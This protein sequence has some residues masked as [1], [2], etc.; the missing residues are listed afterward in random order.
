MTFM[1]LCYIQN[2][3]TWCLA[4]TTRHP[5]FLWYNPMFRITFVY[6]LRDF[7]PDI[8][9]ST[10]LAKAIRIVSNNFC[11]LIGFLRVNWSDMFPVLVFW[12]SRALKFFVYSILINVTVMA[13][14]QRFDFCNSEI[15]CFCLL[16]VKTRDKRSF[17]YIRTI[18]VLELHIVTSRILR[19]SNY[20]KVSFHI[21]KIIATFKFFCYFYETICAL[22]K[23]FLFSQWKLMCAKQIFLI[24]ENKCSWKVIF[25]ELTK[26]NKQKMT[27]IVDTL[28]RSSFEIKKW[29]TWNSK[30]AFHFFF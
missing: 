4:S 28:P 10:T 16:G 19:C 3:N 2:I 24:C 15:S 26:I 25:L 7:P 14:N 29:F 17:C 27:Q 11:S 5:C 18:L 12:L 13:V 30:P 9:P 20:C 6:K 8:S 21:S 22:D 23:W 1:N